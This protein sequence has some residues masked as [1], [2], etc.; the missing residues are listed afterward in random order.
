M[1][2]KILTLTF[3]ILCGTVFW[4]W[5]FNQPC[6]PPDKPIVVP[7]EAAW[8]GDCDG[9]HWVE[10]V[11]IKKEKVRFRIYQDWNGELILDAD[12]NYRNCD[13]L[14]LTNSNWAEYISYFDESLKINETSNTNKCRL[15]PIYPAYQH[16]KLE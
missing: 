10:L 13:N 14:K 9:G 15:E 12:F 7:K 6:S 11:S 3:L 4:K 2:K 5:F 8:K 1:K 16:D